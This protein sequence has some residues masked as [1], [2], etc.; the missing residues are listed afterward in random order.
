MATD[1]FLKLDGIKGESK[2]D[3]HKD[4]IE[5]ESFSFGVRQEGTS[6]KGGGLGAGRATFPDLNIVKL[7]DK[8]SPK[9]F[10]NCA[11]GTHIKE[12]ILIARKAGG[13]Q[14][15]YYKVKLT[16]LLVSNWE[17]RG[18][19]ANAVPMEQVSFNYSKI[20]I[21]YKE[22]DAKGALTGVVTANYDLKAN[23]GG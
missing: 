22:Q 6:S 21:E 16:D 23:K 5:I 7:A 4:E 1:F 15:E 13:K 12:G 8:A 20:E 10:L 17:N 11:Q 19:G 3:K 9:L 2:D 14:E 18:A